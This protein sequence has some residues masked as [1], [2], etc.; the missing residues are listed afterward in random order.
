MRAL[1]RVSL[2]ATFVFA[3]GLSRP[4][5]ACGQQVHDYRFKVL[6][7]APFMVQPS[8]IARVP[9]EK[10]SSVSFDTAGIDWMVSGKVVSARRTP[11]QVLM[12]DSAGDTR[13]ILGFSPDAPFARGVSA[14]VRK[15]GQLVVVDGTLRVG[16]FTPQGRPVRQYQL[17]DTLP[18][19][20]RILLGESLDRSL[21]ALATYSRGPLW[22]QV[23]ANES[24][25]RGRPVSF[26]DSLVVILYD[27]TGATKK[28]LGPFLGVTRVVH[29]VSTPVQ[30]RIQL[31][32][33][34]LRPWR[35][36]RSAA[37]VFG[38][39]LLTVYMDAERELVRYD[40]RGTIKCRVLIDGELERGPA[41]AVPANLVRNL[42]LVADDSGNVWFEITKE[43]RDQAEWVVLDPG[44][45]SVGRISL[46][47]GFRLLRVERGRLMGVSVSAS[48]SY[49]ETY[50]LVATNQPKGD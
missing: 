1:R 4:R 37:A 7:Q 23:H 22:Q 12:H 11:S 28:I 3:G 34:R 29:V 42:G 24:L 16:E 25:R 41:G 6:A 10:D 47:K 39:D 15:D 33:Q 14:L 45:V 5:A 27:S 36:L 19:S 18:A 48:G 49:A 20:S 30:E 9:V 13:R 35:E 44:C 32:T 43:G 50:R 2:L 46:P 40:L 21:V 26:R 8:P 38:A 17:R 31:S